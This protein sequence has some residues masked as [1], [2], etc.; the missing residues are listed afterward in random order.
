MMRFELMHI[1]KYV[2]IL[3]VF[4]LTSCIQIDDI[5]SYWDKA[6]LDKSLKGYWAELNDCVNIV[7]EGSNYRIIENG[8][9]Q[10]SLYRTL[11]LNNNKF[12]I[13]KETNNK[14]L[15][16]RYETTKN[17]LIIYYPNSTKKEEFLKEYPE[18]NAYIDENDN[19][20]IKHLNEESI[21]LLNK[22]ANNDSYW[23]TKS[24]PRVKNCNQSNAGN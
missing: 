8:K 9:K 22:A 3:P 17:E 18:S 15:L 13:I 7:A 24:I 4:I 10:N 23:E 2:L 16:Q 19:I 12:L 1:V 6:T 14:Y 11:I 5:G 20:I 21:S